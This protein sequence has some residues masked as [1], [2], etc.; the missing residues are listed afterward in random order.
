MD[1]VKAVCLVLSHS[2]SPPYDNECGSHALPE[3]V[4]GQGM[5]RKKLVAPHCHALEG[6]P[7]YVGFYVISVLAQDT[8]SKNRQAMLPL[9]PRC[10]MR[11]VSSVMD[12]PTA[13]Y[14]TMGFS[15][16]SWRRF[17]LTAVANG[18]ALLM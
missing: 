5:K 1:G 4:V 6:A 15:T 7:I 8:L 16:V 11:G 9:P 18:L 12:R 17:Y 3:S 13:S 14:R 10:H 2:P